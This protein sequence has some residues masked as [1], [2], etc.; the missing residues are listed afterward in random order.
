MVGSFLKARKRSRFHGFPWNDRGWIAV[1]RFNALVE[2]G[3]QF[4]GRLHRILL[5][6][7]AIPNIFNEPHA[8]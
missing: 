7:E 4:D 2:K 6:R 3:F 1:E 8:L 5:G